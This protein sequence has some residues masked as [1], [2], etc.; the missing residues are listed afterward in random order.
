M[1][2]GVAVAVAV[3]AAAAAAVGREER[4]VL[5][6]HHVGIAGSRVHERAISGSRERLRGRVL[7]LWQELYSLGGDTAAV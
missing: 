6:E 5:G 3:A 2:G 4:I 1:V 7:L